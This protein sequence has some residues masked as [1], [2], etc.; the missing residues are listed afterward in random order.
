MK[1]K[2]HKLS[3]PLSPPWSRREFLEFLGKGSAASLLLANTSALVGCQS[4][5]KGDSKGL[6]PSLKDKVELIPGLSYRVLVEAGAPINS[7]DKFGYNNDFVVF[8]PQTEN[9]ALLWVNHESI[10]PYLVSGRSP[11]DTPTKNQFKVERQQVGGSVIKIVKEAGQWKLDPTSR[12]AFRLDATTKIPFANNKKISGQRY[13]IGTF[14]NCSGGITPWNTILSCEENY[15]G[16]VGEVIFSK[17]GKSKIDK[18]LAYYKWTK[19]FSPPPEHYGWVIEVNPKTKKAKKHTALGRFAHEGACVVQLADKRVVVYM[20]DDANDEC[21]YKFISRKPNSLDQGELFVADFQR[22]KWVSLNRSKS[23]LLQ[24]QFK[25]Q[26]DV[27]IRTREAAKMMGG[28]PMNRPEDIERDPLTG[29]IIVATTN[30]IPKNDYYGALIK[31]D[32]E[33]NDPTSMNFTSS[34]L[35][36]GGPKSG[37]ACPD[38]IVFAPNGDMWFTVDIA[39]RLIDTGAYKGFGNNSLFQV[40]RKGPQAGEAIRIA[41]A[42]VDSEFCGPY[43]SPD[44]KTL[45]LAVQHPG[46]G[47]VPGQEYSSHWP[48]GG[49]TKPNPAVIAITG[50]YFNKV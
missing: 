4:L 22:N 38:N 6:R 18:S 39:E 50:E 19:H 35:L 34:T 10:S 14:A 1:S 23:L 33:N 24:T 27:L 11:S 44:G 12:E 20:G 15:D 16:F 8:I 42:P 43:F 21:I 7:K 25:T 17:S 28:T 9:E 49:A 3:A 40:P 46:K 41:N 13:A 47:S 2:M 29:S 37:F 36:S 26:E 32:E 48:H 31:I 30:N 45:F 5:S